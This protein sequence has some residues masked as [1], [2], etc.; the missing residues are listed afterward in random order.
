MKRE[1]ER[2]RCGG[3]REEEW[4]RTCH[5]R[6]FKQHHRWIIR[7]KTSPLLNLSM[8]ALLHKNSWMSLIISYVLKTQ[9]SFFILPYSLAVTLFCLCVNSLVC[10]NSDLI[11]CGVKAQQI[12]V[13]GLLAVLGVAAVHVLGG[14][15]LQHGGQQCVGSGVLQVKYTGGPAATRCV[16]QRHR[17]PLWVILP[18]IKLNITTILNQRN[19]KL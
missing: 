14:R 16:I 5:V 12:S 1:D 19:L 11:R 15:A 7:E 3:E 13:A 9:L 18:Q 2:Q 8:T 4:Q 17:L 10:V 6:K